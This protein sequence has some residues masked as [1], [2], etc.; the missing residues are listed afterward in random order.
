MRA[1]SRQSALSIYDT[2]RSMERV[3][4]AQRYIAEAEG[5]DLRAMV[6]DG[7]VVGAFRRR[8]RAGEFR[9]NIHRGGSAEIV[10][11]P[12]SY[13][14]LATGAASALGLALAGVDLL[15]TRHGPAV[16]EVNP[17]PGWKQIE[18]LS[19]IDV[20]ARIVDYLERVGEMDTG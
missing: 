10:D 12:S 15:E 4:L 16:L 7:Q 13:R 18:L 11:L 20:T 3:V 1:D 9:S 5:S 14:A 17:S 2:L 6:V 8:A 19:D